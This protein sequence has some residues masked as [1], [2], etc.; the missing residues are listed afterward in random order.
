MFSCQIVGLNMHI[1]IVK[2]FQRLKIIYFPKIWL[3][4]ET[5]ARGKHLRKYL[6]VKSTRLCQHVMQ[7]YSTGEHEEH[8]FY[9]Q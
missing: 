3:L 2:E 7:Q 8:K 9:R 5:D 4:S 1:H 6:T